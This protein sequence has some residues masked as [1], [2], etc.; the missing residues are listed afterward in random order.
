MIGKLL[1]P[2]AIGGGLLLLLSS[3]AKAESAPRNPFDVLP[4]NLRV[5]AAQAQATNDPGLLDQTA[6]QLEMQGFPQAAGVLRMQ[7]EQIR[8]IRAG[9]TPA[10]SV[11]AF[12][13][14]TASSE[15]LVA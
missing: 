5:L 11:A 1:I 6:A 15:A 2:V 9:T 7:A 10:A 12:A 14:S 4:S 8:R 3:S 13:D